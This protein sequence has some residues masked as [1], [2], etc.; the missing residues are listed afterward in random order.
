[1]PSFIKEAHSFTKHDGVPH[2][3]LKYTEYVEGE[4]Y[5]NRAALFA[6]KPVGNWKDFV[7]RRDSFRYTDFLETM[8]HMTLEIRRELVRLQLEN[9]IC[10]NKNIFSIIRIMN[11]I[12]ILDP[13]FIPPVINV[14]CAWQKQF[15]KH[16]CTDTLVSVANT[17]KNEYRL[18]RLYTT[19]LKIE[20]EL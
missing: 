17:C 16:M 19:L 9:V 1:M 3:E 14:Q 13:T 6:T 10:E 20:E 7:S 11:C 18:E 12:K 2:V 15:C 8:V 4:G 5:V